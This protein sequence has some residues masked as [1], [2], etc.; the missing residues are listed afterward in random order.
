MNESGNTGLSQVRSGPVVGW[1]ILRDGRHYGFHFIS[2]FYEHSR[3]TK[4]RG[5]HGESYSELDHC[6]C[7]RGTYYNSACLRAFKKAD[8]LGNFICLCKNCQNRSYL[9]KIWHADNAYH[10]HAFSAIVL[11]CLALS[12]SSSH[13]RCSHLWTRS[14]CCCQSRIQWLRHPPHMSTAATDDTLNSIH[15]QIE[16]G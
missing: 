9:A 6:R 2:T 14:R 16:L 11:E 15:V 13:S 12:S 3:P 4:I 8:S 10:F 1:G 7:P 5:H